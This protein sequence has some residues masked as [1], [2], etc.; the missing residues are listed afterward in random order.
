MF[1][2]KK[3][4]SRPELWKLKNVLCFAEAI[5]ESL[6]VPI[7]DVE[8]AWAREIEDRVATFDRGEMPAYPAEAVLRRNALTHRAQRYSSLRRREQ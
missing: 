7:A 4:N 3:S 8:A 5:L 2:L 1:P 6:H